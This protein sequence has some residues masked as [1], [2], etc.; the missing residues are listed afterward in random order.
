[1]ESQANTLPEIWVVSSA[2]ETAPGQDYIVLP[3]QRWLD[4]DSVEPRVAKQCV[5]MAIIHSSTEESA[6]RKDKSSSIGKGLLQDWYDDGNDQDYRNGQRVSVPA[7][8]SIEYQITGK[9][10]FE[11]AGESLQKNKE[12]QIFD[13]E[14]PSAFAPRM[15]LLPNGGWGYLDSGAADA[16]TMNKDPELGTAGSAA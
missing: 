16:D 8:V 10:E 7:G 13:L 2:I 9:V 1:M 5:A 4:G 3:E 12:K 11:V 14:Q 6:A 15:G